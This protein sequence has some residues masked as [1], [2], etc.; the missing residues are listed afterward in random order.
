LVQAQYNDLRIAPIFVARGG[1]LKHDIP[2]LLE[3]IGLRYPGVRIRLL[4]AAGE[5]DSVIDAMATWIATA[6]V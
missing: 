5:V 2:E 4:P 3:A 1:H 6:A